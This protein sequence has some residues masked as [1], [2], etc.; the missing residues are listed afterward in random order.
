MSDE[1]NNER[2]KDIL[3]YLQLCLVGAITSNVRAIF[4]DWDTTDVTVYFVFDGQI[5]E[6]DQEIAS[7]AHT[8]F[9][10]DLPDNFH[11][12]RCIRIDLPNPIPQLG[13]EC[14]YKRKE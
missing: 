14:V 6:E 4:V 7:C 9:I 1:E 8:E 10:S 5:S 3:V 13:R 11:D 12:F 2:R